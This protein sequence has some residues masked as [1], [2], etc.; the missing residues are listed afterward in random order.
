MLIAVTGG[1]SW[2]KP[3]SAVAMPRLGCDHLINSTQEKMDTVIIR[4]ILCSYA[5]NLCLQPRR[6]RGILPLSC[7][8][9]SGYIGENI[10]IHFDKGNDLP[11]YVR[12]LSLQ[13]E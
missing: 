11:L 8:L 1:K 10:G 13:A 7:T 6:I 12:E 5:R 3:G 9:L 2:R 4:T